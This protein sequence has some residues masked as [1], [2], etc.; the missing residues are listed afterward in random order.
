MTQTYQGGTMTETTQTPALTAEKRG[1]IQT[2]LAE[3]LLLSA[4]ATAVRRS[5]LSPEERDR[6]LLPIMARRVVVEMALFG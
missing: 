3:L 2:L 4:A 5:S 6:R 1:E